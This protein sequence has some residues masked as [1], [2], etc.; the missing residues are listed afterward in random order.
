MSMSKDTIQENTRVW[1]RLGP[2]S[3]GGTVFGLALSPK[4][5]EDRYW[6]AT[7]CGIFVTDDSGAAWSQNLAGLTTPLLSALVVTADGVLF[8]GAMSGDLLVSRDQGATWQVGAVSEELHATITVLAPSPN[9]AKDGTVFAATDGAGLLVS[10]DSGRTWEA[11]EEGLGDD[12]VLALAVAPKWGKRETLFAATPV[13]VY[14]SNDGGR[15]WRVTGLKPEDD[16]IDA[17]AISPKY[18]SDH[19][20]LAGTESGALYRSTNS[21][22]DWTLLHAPLGTGPLNCL[23]FGEGAEPS[24]LAASGMA[25]H[26]STDGGETWTA[27]ADLPDIVLALAGKGDVVLAGMYDAG[28]SKSEDGGLTWSSCA[29]GLAARGFSRLVVVGDDLYAMGPQEGL[30]RSSDDGASWEQ[31]GGLDDHLPLMD[32]TMTAGGRLLIASQESGILRALEGDVWEVACDVPG[33]GSL[34]VSAADGVGWAG[35]VDGRLLSS[36]DG[37]LTWALTDSPCEGQEVLALTISPDYAHDATVLM[38]TAAPATDDR[39]ARVVLWRS[40]N[41][42][43]EWRQIT[44]QVTPARW[45]EIAVPMGA[46][47]DPLSQAILATGPYCLR[48]LRR[49]KDVWIS[50]KVDPD[51]ANTLSVA[52]VAVADGDSRAFAATGNG[53]YV[54]EDGGRS[55]QDYSGGLTSESF[56]SIAAG[57]DTTGYMLYT[58]SLGG[59]LWKRA[60][61]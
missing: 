19:T 28:I 54:S 42:G 1:E 10:R 37:G 45:M 23:W 8:A 30:W 59:L 41:G 3:S 48:P 4:K 40:D 16:V 58:L 27:T 20:V 50:T 17:L 57:E 21:G 18:G 36:K 22:N 39:P 29:E 31:V 12:S 15:S 34:A 49:A 47:E 2:I 52:A 53:I 33:I 6:A 13:G 5:G 38:G 60:L 61:S 26:R 46:P 9:F 56:I 32:L 14:R 43:R 24:L 44:T 55:W 7:G 35:T 11:C 25:I 51:G